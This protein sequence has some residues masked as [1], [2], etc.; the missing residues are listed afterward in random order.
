MTG[1]KFG[2]TRWGRCG[3][4]QLGDFPFSHDH[5]AHTG[6]DD[7]AD[8]AGIFFGQLQAGV[9]QC[10]FGGDQRKLRIPVHPFGLDTIEI[11]LR[12]EAVNLACD[13]RAVAVHG[14]RVEARDRGHA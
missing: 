6:A 13:L 3:L 11:P 12:G 5:T 1:M 7:D 2:W 8:P 9:R 14:K 4:V 10:F